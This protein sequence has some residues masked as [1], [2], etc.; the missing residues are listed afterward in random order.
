MSFYKYRLLLT[1]RHLKIIEAIFFF[2][3]LV[4]AVSVSSGILGFGLT[5]Y[6]GQ[7]AS[8]F[9]G[10]G[11]KGFFYAG[12]ELGA[13]LLCL[14]PIVFITSKTVVRKVTL[15]LI[16]IF[17]SFLIGTKTAF[18]SVFFVAIYSVFLLIKISIL[19]KVTL[20][21]LL[22]TSFTAIFIIFQD[23]IYFKIDAI[24]YVY[25]NKGIM[26]LI[27]S[28]RDSMFNEAFRY[29][30]NNFSS[31]D[32]IFG[33]GSSYAGSKFKSVEMDFADILIWSG[34]I[35]FLFVYIFYFC[36]SFYVLF[37]LDKKSKKVFGLTLFF[38]FVASLL[39]G[40]VLTSG[41]LLPIL[42]LYLPYSY[43]YSKAKFRD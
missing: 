24:N 20:F 1:R 3:F 38:L 17:I 2:N 19:N 40:H 22:L 21:I 6:G 16:F 18:I 9:R 31:P 8:E 10:I 32:F 25:S 30:T 26:Y 33:V 7:P 13:L 39:A 43:V 34:V 14:F 29:T 35:W 27:L 37:L 11:Y 28:G 5:T 15:S 36:F 23:Q 42:S 12:N 41:M 4:I